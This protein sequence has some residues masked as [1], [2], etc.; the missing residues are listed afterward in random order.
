[1]KKESIIPGRFNFFILGFL[2]I[3]TLVGCQPGHKDK[4]KSAVKDH[5]KEKAGKDSDYKPKSFG[6]I[7]SVY[8]P[9]KSTNKFQELTDT[10]KLSAEIFG[11][12]TKLNTALPS[13]KD[14][15]KKVLKHKQQ[16]MKKRRSMIENF[17]TNYEPRLV[18]Y[19]IPHDYQMAD[20]QQKKI[21][22][23]DT[24]YNVVNSKPS[25]EN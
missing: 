14:S 5:L 12:K 24:A 8:L 23:V 3:F 18:G 19:K 6:T 13:N 4:V 1:M 16:N 15:F 10:F 21:F 22:R 11:L 25:L 9:L 2:A 7:D 20:S 17:K